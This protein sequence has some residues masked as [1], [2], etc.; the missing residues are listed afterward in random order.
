MSVCRDAAQ[1]R[2]WKEKELFFFCSSGS[3]LWGSSPF[4]GWAWQALKNTHSKKTRMSH[5]PPQKTPANGLGR[6][7]CKFDWARIGIELHTAY[8]LRSPLFL[9]LSAGVGSHRGAV[10]PLHCGGSDCRGR[11]W[12]SG[13][14]FI[15]KPT[16]GVGWKHFKEDESD[17]TNTTEVIWSF[18][19]FS[20]TMHSQR[21]FF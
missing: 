11:Q 15:R 16:T 13:R 9:L 4:P 19:V 12:D 20:I 1:V 3:L 17:S 6:K 14:S 5:N 7:P 21:D 8:S 18:C 10:Q 2:P